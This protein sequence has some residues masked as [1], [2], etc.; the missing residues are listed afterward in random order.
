MKGRRV[1]GRRPILAMAGA[2][3]AAALTGC[4]DDDGP[5]PASATPGGA[6]AGPATPS[7]AAPSASPTSI[8]LAKL[9]DDEFFRALPQ[10]PPKLWEDSAI[11]PG[12]RLTVA[13]N[14]PGT[15]DFVTTTAGTFNYITTVYS[16]LM[17]TSYRTGRK[18][19]V[20]PE[21]EPDLAVKWERPDETTMLF[22]LAP[23]IKWQNV[24]PLNGRPLTAKD[25]AF[26]FDRG[27]TYTGS[28]FK[29]TFAIFEKVEDAGNNQLRVKLARPEPIAEQYLTTYY[30]SVISPEI[31]ENA[32]LVKT[33][34]VGTGGF[35]VKSYTPNVELVYDKN[36]D[37]FKTD[38]QNRRKPYLDGYTV[39]FFGDRDAMTNAFQVGQAETYVDSARVVNLD[40]VR[41]L[42]R[43]RP[44]MELWFRP[45]TSVSYAVIG[46]HDR[47]PWKDQRVRQA[48]SM[49]VP[50]E[51]MAKTLYRGYAH[52][53]PYFAWPSVYDQPP[54]LDQLG[55][56]YK[57]DPR[58]AK[59]LLQAAGLGSG[60]ELDLD[61]WDLQDIPKYAALLQ[62]EAAAIGVK[63]N[64][65]KSP[66]QAQHFVKVNGKSWKDLIFHGRGTD[67]IDP[68]ATVRAYVTG[69]AQNASDVS[70]PA[71]DDLYKKILPASGE[72]RKQIGKQMWD[73]INQ[74]AYDV[75]F[76]SQW[77]LGGWNPRMRN[78][79]MTT[80]SM[81]QMD[82]TWAD[83]TAKW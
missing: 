36:P 4:G 46:H 72:S 61:F 57:Y 63:L 40:N 34:M 3:A 47:G 82:S 49:L 8:E 79:T 56:A 45:P 23:G 31:G 60:L 64:L 51:K 15:W 13:S 80:F 32:D 42:Q 29:S 71:M 14:V 18:S 35:M 77:A 76:P 20:V 5:T 62:E 11:T 38:A 12:G 33:K 58:E 7:A 59:A 17:R 75:T 24:A 55:P 65:V 16:L 44:A 54:A 6:P 74:Q 69:L 26:S 10:N 28:I 30:M 27:K 53:G 43:R 2:A 21:T 25:V 68:V 70:D 66:D 39:R 83:L 48:L 81:G 67:F 1:L 78:H 9:S 50:R 19:S 73:R 52:H 37:F 22:T 41:D